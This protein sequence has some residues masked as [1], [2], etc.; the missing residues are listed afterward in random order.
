VLIGVL[1]FGLIGYSR[2]EVQHPT[3]TTTTT[4]TTIGPSLSS[5]WYSGLGFDVCG[6]MT[7]LAANPTTKDAGIKSQG[8]GILL[9]APGSVPNSQDFV[10]NGNTLRN[11]VI[12]YEPRMTLTDTELQLPG[13][14]LYKNG[15]LCDGKPAKVQ[16]KLW[17]SFASPSG[18]LVPKG[19]LDKKMENGQMMT[20]AFAPEGATIPSIPAKSIHELSILYQAS[21]STTTPSTPSTV[22]PTTTVVGPTVPATSSTTP[23][24]TTS[25]VAGSSTTSS[26]PASGTTTTVASSTSST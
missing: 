2:Y 12:H 18:E 1:G 9:T 19:A 10:G 25:S 5:Q 21:Q 22:V 26:A 15:D 24:A 23:G 7:L 6:K 13:Q 20:V 11:F 16:F 14:K 4:T 3:T 8:N 17:P